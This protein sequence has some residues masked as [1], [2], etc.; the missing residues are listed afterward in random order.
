[1]SLRITASIERDVFHRVLTIG[2]YHKLPSTMMADV[3]KN[4]NDI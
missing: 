3:I 4:L 2:T 1:M